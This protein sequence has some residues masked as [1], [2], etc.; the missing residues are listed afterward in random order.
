MAHRRLCGL[1]PERIAHRQAGHCL[2]AG[3]AN[4]ALGVLGHRYLHLRAGLAQA[5][6]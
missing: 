3:G 5:A 6:H 2:Q 4:E 1:V